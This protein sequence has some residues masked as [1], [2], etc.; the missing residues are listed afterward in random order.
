MGAITPIPLPQR[1]DTAIEIPQYKVQYRWT[2]TSRSIL[3]PSDPASPRAGCPASAHQ[4]ANTALYRRIPPHPRPLPQGPPGRVSRPREHTIAALS[5]NDRDSPH[6]G[7]IDADTRVVGTVELLLPDNC[8][9]VRLSPPRAQKRPAA[10][11]RSQPTQAR[12]S[13]GPARVPAVRP[14]RPERSR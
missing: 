4:G 12:V 7:V 11:H 10:P 9:D 2:S 5:K 14:V 13:L 3:P 8:N 6:Q 1:L